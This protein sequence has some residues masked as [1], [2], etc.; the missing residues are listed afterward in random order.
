MSY[1]VGDL[2]KL[3]NPDAEAEVVQKPA[4]TGKKASNAKNYDAK[5]T[6]DKSTQKALFA[7]SQLLKE[8]G[9]QYKQRGQRLQLSDNMSHLLSQVPTK[10]QLPQAGADDSTPVAESDDDNDDDTRVDSWKKPSTDVYANDEDEDQM[11]KVAVSDALL[12]ANLVRIPDVD[13]A[14]EDDDTNTKAPKPKHRSTKE[15]AERDARTIFL[16]NV[17]TSATTKTIG[18]FLASAG[19]PESIRFRSISFED[20]KLPKR[21]AFAQ[22]KFH[23]SR[24]SM[25]AYAVM[26]TVEAARAALA[27]NTHEFEGHHVFVDLA[28]NPSQ[29]DVYHS[30]FVGNLSFALGEEAVYQHFLRCG[31]IARVR[32]VRDAKLNIGKGFGFVTFVN[33][34]SVGE[35]LNLAGSSLEGLKVRVTKVSPHGLNKDSVAFKTLRAKQ[36]IA[37][38]ASRKQNAIEA[39]LE[40]RRRQLLGDDDKSSG[41]DR[42]KRSKVQGAFQKVYHQKSSEAGFTS[43]KPRHEP[44]AN[45]GKLQGVLTP[46][47]WMGRTASQ[48]DSVGRAK[49][50]T[51]K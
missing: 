4:K 44:R 46:K 43:K 5:V 16:S 22:K 29:V 36:D 35:A 47:S 17:P 42:A 34:F 32:I 50:S 40:K 28:S 39:R 19:V 6:L 20:P 10:L 24:D 7:A 13:G 23:P 3:L 25:N 14:D 51:K 26:P 33:K 30:V 8:K 38:Q 11:N 2:T 21:V 15:A 27:L 45:S 37:A 9:R 41:N 12:A 49:K 1:N 48:K 31:D 18:E